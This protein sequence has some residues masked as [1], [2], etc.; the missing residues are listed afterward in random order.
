MI[1]GNLL[2]TLEE[3]S[4]LGH[5][6]VYPKAHVATGEL[7]EHF[8]DETFEISCGLDC[9][10]FVTFRGQTVRYKSSDLVREA[11]KTISRVCVQDNE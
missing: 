6:Y 5:F 10:V 2:P 3:E 8:P 11:I 9:A 4:T 7:G 1:E